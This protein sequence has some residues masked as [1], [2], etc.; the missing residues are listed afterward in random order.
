V[1]CVFDTNG[2]GTQFVEPPKSTALVDAMAYSIRVD[3]CKNA[4]SNTTLIHFAEEDVGF[5][6]RYRIQIDDMVCPNHDHDLV[7]HL[8]AS[9]SFRFNV[10]VLQDIPLDSNG[11]CGQI[12]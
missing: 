11:G 6:G 12:L 9:R 1:A 7:S 3:E 10:S 2:N 8:C 5:F 4:R